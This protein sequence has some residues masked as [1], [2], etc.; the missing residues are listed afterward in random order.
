VVGGLVTMPAP[1]PP[2]SVLNSASVLGT[3]GVPIEVFRA[4]TG[5]AM[6]VAVIASVELFEHETDRILA[7]ARRRELL[8][9]ER[10]RIGRDLHDGII[11]SIYAAGLHLEEAAAVAGPTNGAQ[12]RFQTVLGELNRIAEDIRSTIFDLRSAEQDALDAE[13]LVAAVADELHANT[14][15]VVDL[16]TEGLFRARL[17]AEQADHLRN[18]LTEAFSNVMRHAQARRVTVRMAG[19]RRRLRIEIT[20]DGVGFDHRRLFVDVPP[21]LVWAGVL[22]DEFSHNRGAVPDR[23]SVADEAGDCCAGSDGDSVTDVGAVDD[24]RSVANCAVVA[25]A[26]AVLDDAVVSDLYAFV[27]DGVVAD[28]TIRPDGNGPAV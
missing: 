18:I 16:R 21:A 6:A 9:R 2:A 28:K 13:Q 1:F 17:S 12:R 20:D 10:E 23:G 26:N 15:M 7:Y 3:F 5:L 19:S 8:L 11:Q 25:D 14:A 24:P 27:D 22:V 4:I